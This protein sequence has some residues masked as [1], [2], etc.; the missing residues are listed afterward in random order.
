MI[1]NPYIFGAAGRLFDTFGSSLFGVSVRRLNTS[2]SADDH[3]GRRS[4]DNAETN[5]DFDGEE[6]SLSSTVS[7]GGDYATWATTDNVF[8]TAWR[9]QSGNGFDVTQA[10]MV[11]QPQILNA[12]ALITKNGKPAFLFDGTTDFM[13]RTALSAMDDGNVLSFFSVT[14]ATSGGV[15]GGIITNHTASD[16]LTIFHDTRATPTRNLF[17]DSTTGNFF[18]DLSA[19]RNDTN[20]HLLSSFIDSSQNMAG[21]DNGATGGTDTYTG[22]YNNS[23]FEIG[24]TLVGP[25]FH[26]GE[27]QEVIVFSADHLSNRTAIESDIDTFYSV[28]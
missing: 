10:T 9:D 21:F 24:R 25:L 27:I 7:V 15:A 8:A 22:V 28:P 1:I 17:V 5:V 18:A 16:R 13:D 2:Y 23:T 12:G 26:G 3:R 14:S 11:N 6:Y 4:S 20:Q 19:A